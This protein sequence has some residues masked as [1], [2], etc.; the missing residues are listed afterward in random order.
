MSSPLTR[1][2][3]TP[4]NPA[5]AA[6]AGPA[7]Q[8]PEMRPEAPKS[9]GGLSRLGIAVAIG[10]FVIVAALAL[11]YDFGGGSADADQKPPVLAGFGNKLSN[12]Y[13]P[14][15]PPPAKEELP[16]K[17]AAAPRLRQ[18]PQRSRQVLLFGDALGN[19]NN[20][21]AA[22]QVEAWSRGEGYVNLA[23]LEAEAG[24]GH[25]L[26]SDGT[27]FQA[28][29]RGGTLQLLR[30][31]FGTDQRNG[32]TC[33][34]APAGS[35][36]ALGMAENEDDPICVIRLDTVGAARAS[37]PIDCWEVFGASGGSGRTNDGTVYDI[38]T[39]GDL[40]TKQG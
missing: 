25:C 30:P 11:A 29:Q 15:D 5:S 24:Q 32:A 31:L 27:V 16:P 3:A 2:G 36:V 1:P 26:V 7:M 35:T 39:I 23:Q 18:E 33:R 19:P 20:A 12:E 22:R 13:K 28:Q 14:E 17:K 34:A 10:A 9:R 21:I 38:R 4:P 8:I 6:P 40:T 37:Y